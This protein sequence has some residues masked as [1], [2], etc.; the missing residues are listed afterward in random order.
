MQMVDGCIMIW[1]AT[2]TARQHAG[3]LMTKL[4]IPADPVI[5]TAMGGVLFLGVAAHQKRGLD[6]GLSN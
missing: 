6:W 5:W 2:T 1:T 4:L 3:S